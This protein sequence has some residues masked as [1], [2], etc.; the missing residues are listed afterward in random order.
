LLQLSEPGGASEPA[1]TAL[2]DASVAA[3]RLRANG[4]A[5]VV[6]DRAVAPARL[7]EYVER[8]LPLELIASEGDRQ[9]YVVK[10]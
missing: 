9:L 2:A 5:F 6:L 1:P 7:T 3:E 8:V 4:I 10:K